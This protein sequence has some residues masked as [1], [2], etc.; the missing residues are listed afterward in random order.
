[1]DTWYYSTGRPDEEHWTS[2]GFDARIGRNYGGFINTVAIL[3]ESP[4]GLPM[5]HAALAAKYGYHA[6]AEW[7]GDNAG[8]L[9]E[10]VRRARVETIE[11]GT[12]AE[13]AV[14]TDQEYGPDDDPVSY[15][16]LDGRGDDAQEIAVTGAQHMKKPV[17]TASRPRP[18]AYILPR[19][20]EGAV[21]LLR[22]HGISV[23]QLYAPVT[24]TVDAYALEGVERERAYNHDAAARVMLGET[25]TRQMAFPQ[26][27]YVVQTGQMLGRLVGHMLEPETN[28]NVV[29]WNTMD[30][31]LP[32]SS[33]G[34]DEVPLVPIYKL[35][36][37]TPLPAK[38][39]R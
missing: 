27:S 29:Y 22:R 37:A 9:M 25:V 18:W 33:I 12:A 28:D 19:D 2:G 30:A 3:F 32:E 13:G 26:G 14:V 8:T 16:L 31:W 1:M 35:M 17:V 4:P 10:T 15:R 20:A 7:A 11:M 5:E 6:V 23:E 21:A 38:L 24:V 34:S 36:E 39:I